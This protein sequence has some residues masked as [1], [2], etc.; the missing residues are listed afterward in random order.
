[1]KTSS[2]MSDAIGNVVQ[3]TVLITV[4]ISFS[5][6]QD[7]LFQRGR[8]VAL[9]QRDQRAWLMQ[10]AGTWQ[11]IVGRDTQV[12]WRG[13]PLADEKALLVHSTSKVNGALVRESWGMWV[14]DPDRD[15]ILCMT[16]LSTG[17]ILQATGS[18]EKRSKLQ[19][20][21]GVVPVPADQATTTT[22][23]LKPPDTFE[24]Y[25]TDPNSGVSRVFVYT[26]VVR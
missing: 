1:M 20:T 24:V 10:F 13:T 4:L 3:M 19:L 25:Q 7:S 2:R 6:A 18:F 9:F 8:Q 14:F 26:C 16:V 22:M 21:M 11:T 5:Q 23:E 15:R 17:E 12:V